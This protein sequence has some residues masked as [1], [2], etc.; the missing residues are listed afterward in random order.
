MS[1]EVFYRA[2]G[3]SGDWVVDVRESR[4]G[5]IEVLV[6]PPDPE[7]TPSLQCRACRGR[8]V[9]VHERKLR[10]WREAPFAGKPVQIVMHSP[11]V[12]CLNC[13]AKWTCPRIACAGLRVGLMV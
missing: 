8:R 13:G 9:H 4:G 2:M 10:S 7:G 12:R 1:A 5:V 11:R 3:L 6:E